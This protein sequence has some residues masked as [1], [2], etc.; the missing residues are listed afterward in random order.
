MSKQWGH[1]YWRGS[2]AAQAQAGTLAGLW[3][4]SRKNG[5]VEWQGC[6]VR[7]LRNGNYVVQLFEW[8]MGT[9]TVQ[10]VISFGEMKEWDFYAT[11]RAMRR[12]WNNIQGGSEA[13]FEW[14]EKNVEF[15]KRACR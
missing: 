8:A 11:D 6:V 7:H 14:S 12:A 4:H 13:D 2:E 1:G 9:P 15:L 3:F 5:M 10:K